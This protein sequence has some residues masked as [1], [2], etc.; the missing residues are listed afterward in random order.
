MQCR[1]TNKAHGPIKGNSPPLR[2]SARSLSSAL[3]SPSRSRVP[4]TPRA[5]LISFSLEAPPLDPPKGSRHQGLHLARD[6]LNS[7]GDAP[8]H[9]SDGRIQCP[10]RQHAVEVKRQSLRHA[11]QGSDCGHIHLHRSLCGQLLIR[12]MHALNCADRRTLCC[13][14]CQQLPYLLRRENPRCSMGRPSNM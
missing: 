6:L 14:L 9:S 11:A 8:A 2:P 5:G 12:R 4:T 3:Q 7:R 1:P 10:V 13:P